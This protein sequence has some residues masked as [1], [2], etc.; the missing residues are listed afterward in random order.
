MGLTS[1]LR[2]VWQNEKHSNEYLRS[3]KVV[4]ECKNTTE[5]LLQDALIDVYAYGYHVMFDILGVDIIKSGYLRGDDLVKAIKEKATKMHPHYS[6]ELLFWSE[7]ILS[8]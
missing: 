2:N 8:E 3:Y 6:E 1:A 4:E 5:Y 7:V